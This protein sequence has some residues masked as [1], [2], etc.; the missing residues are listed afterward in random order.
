MRF[1]FALAL[2]ITL[3]LL[4]ASTEAAEYKYPYHDPYLATATV[5]ILSNDGATKRVDS[6]I[7]HVPGLPG[8]NNLPDLEGRGDLSLSVYR[9]SQAGAVA[10]HSRRPRVQPLFRGRPVFGEPVLSRGF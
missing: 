2:L 7:L 5:A 9:Q 4:T 1:Y 10:F 3:S 6:T 8:R